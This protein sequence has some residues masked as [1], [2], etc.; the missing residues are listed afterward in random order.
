MMTGGRVLI[1]L[2]KHISNPES[3]ILI[4]GYQAVGTRGRLIQEG[5]KETKIF[6]EF[7]SVNAHIEDIGNLSS[8]G[9]QQD[10]INWLGNIENKPSQV[11]LAHGEPQSANALRVKLQHKYHWQVSIP[12]LFET[13]PMY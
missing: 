2:Q 1:Y 13:Y 6:G 4:T 3:T 12:K 10:L 11:W 9:D 8:H 7:Y 5:A